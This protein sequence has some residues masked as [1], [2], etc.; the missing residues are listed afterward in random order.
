MHSGRA[1]QVWITADARV[2]GRDDLV[3]KLAAK[4]RLELKNATD[5][6]LVLHAYH[7][8]GDDCVEH[9]IGDF[10]FA[11][12]DERRRGLFCA[13]D[14]FGV[15]PFF[16]ARLPHCLVFSNTLN[17]V[18]LHPDVPEALNPRAIEEFLRAEQIRDP[19]ATTYVDIHRLPAGHR[20][21]WS[22]SDGTVRVERYWT[23]PVDES[24]RY[25]RSSDYVDQFL[26]LLRQ[27]VA[28]RLRTRQVAISMSGGLD[29][30]TIAAV[31]RQVLA[32]KPEPFQLEPP[33]PSF[34]TG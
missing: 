2:D 12:W 9:L 10:A 20:L 25:R 34:M 21:R 32:E 33:T 11:I 24:I 23:L 14:H 17:C 4:G 16:Y 13:R 1:G 19:A 15:K 8:W 29:S 7:A 18:R 26:A 22:A 30:T 27:A 28:D 6:E 3:R 5:P 31:A